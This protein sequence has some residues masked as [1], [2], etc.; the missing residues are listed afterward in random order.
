MDHDH[1]DDIFDRGLQFDLKTLLGRRR[2]LGLAAGVGLAG[3]AAATPAFAKA[4]DDS[5][6]AADAA[7]CRTIPTETGGPFPGDGTNGPNILTRSGIV[8]SDLRTSFD[9]GS[10]TAGGVTL[11]LRLT[12]LSAATCAPYD[13]AAVYL[14]GCDRE[15]RYSMYSAGVTQENYCRGVQAAGSSGQLTFTTIFPG[16]YPGRWP[17]LHFE[18]YPSLARATSASGKLKT[19]QLAFPADVCRTV[20][21]SA[22]YQASIPNLARVSLSTDG[23]FRDG[24]SQQMVTISGSPQSGYLASLTITV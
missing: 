7:A 13:A 4:S 12:V 22:G 15:G 24:Y 20:Y 17:H 19:S 6:L 16:C 3:L 9:T 23:V 5:P 2:M 14:W 18:V 11:T 1:H 10:A 8:R 21:Q